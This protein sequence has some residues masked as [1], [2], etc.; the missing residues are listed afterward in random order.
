MHKHK[1][2]HIEECSHH[3]E[4]DAQPNDTSFAH[5][6]EERDDEWNPHIPKMPLTHG[7]GVEL[8]IHSMLRHQ[9]RKRMVTRKVGVPL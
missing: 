4:W 2:Q 1:K 9:A 7:V 5:K 6:E 3:K 8:T